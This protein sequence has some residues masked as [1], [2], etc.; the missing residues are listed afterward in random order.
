[1]DEDMSANGELY[2]M[3]GMDDCVAVEEEPKVEQNEKQNRSPFTINIKSLMGMNQSRKISPN[4][5]KDS[6]RE[7]IASLLGEWEEPMIQ[8]RSIV[9]DLYLYSAKKIFLKFL[10]IIIL[11]TLV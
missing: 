4:D 3:E 8:H 10:I 1:M 9:S 2:E 7:I 11:P 5:L 6:D